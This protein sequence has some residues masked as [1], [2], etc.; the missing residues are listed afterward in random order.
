M[1][2]T[3][4]KQDPPSNQHTTS[5]NTSIRHPPRE[6]HHD[7]PHPPPHPT[8]HTLGGPGR[9]RTIPGSFRPLWRHITGCAGVS[10]LRRHKNTTCCT[11]PRAPSLFR[12]FLSAAVAGHSLYRRQRLVAALSSTII[13]IRTREGRRECIMV[14]GHRQRVH[15][16][17]YNIRRDGNQHVPPLTW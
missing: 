10:S 2:R 13:S 9:R 8:P 4:H 14:L 5:R 3:S 11:T 17:L 6:K 12:A 15:A 16:R 1:R 7:E